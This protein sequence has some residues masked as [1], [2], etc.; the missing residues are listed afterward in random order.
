MSTL[1]LPATD[2]GVMVGDYIA[3]AFVGAQPIGVF[4]V[5]QGQPMPG[6]FNE[7]MYVSKLGILPTRALGRHSSYGERPV[8]GAHSDRLYRLRPP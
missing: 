4:A 5:A 1:W 7:A 6:V 2:E 8:P 3:T